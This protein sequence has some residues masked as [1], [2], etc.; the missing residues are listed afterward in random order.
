[1]WKQAI[2]NYTP[3]NEQE[4]T[5]KRLMV[6]A[7][8]T[9]EDVLVRDNTICHM[10]VS[11]FVVNPEKTHVLMAYHNLYNSWAWLGGHA[12]GDADF[13]YVASKEIEEE[14]GVKNAHLLSDTIFSLE[15]LNVL[16]HV[17]KGKFV[18]AHLHLNVTYLFEASMDEQ[19]VVAENENSNVGWLPIDELAVH[20]TEEFMIPIY[21]K[22][23]KKMREAL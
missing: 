5:D 1:M 14:S 18:S 13:A 12:D 21:E 10:T 17:K 6:R 16:S 15:V 19:L 3:Y 2:Q 9:F 4:E 22:I 20:C 11:S 7:I 8:E 23:V